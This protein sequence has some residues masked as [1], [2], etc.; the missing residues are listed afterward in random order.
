MSEQSECLDAVTESAREPVSAPEDDGGWE[1]AIVEIMGHRRH[2]GRVREVER[3][4]A[5][6]LRI[7]IPKPVAGDVAAEK[8]AQWETV[9][10][11]GAAL[12][13]YTPSDEATIIKHNAPYVSPYRLTH[14]DTAY[15]EAEMPF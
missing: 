14:R 2:A 7:D 8:V 11:P 10:Y 3:F 5:K 9:F 6:L 4:G 15:D 12:F 13:S 1:W